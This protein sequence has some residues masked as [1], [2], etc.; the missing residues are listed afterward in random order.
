MSYETHNDCQTLA[1]LSQ[2]QPDPLAWVKYLPEVGQPI[3]RKLA[4]IDQYFARAAEL[5]QQAQAYRDTAAVLR[6]KL[7]RHLPSL[8]QTEE[9]EAARAKAQR[10]TLAVAAPEA[11]S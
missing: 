11:S 1:S 5:E 8:W 7:L 9:I 2:H 6:E 4:L 3:H 10:L